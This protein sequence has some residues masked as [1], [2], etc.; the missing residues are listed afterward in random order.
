MTESFAT[1]LTDKVEYGGPKVTTWQTLA[2]WLTLAHST[3][4]WMS[5]NFSFLVL[6]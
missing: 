6:V 3:F 4:N 2:Y 5:F 1:H